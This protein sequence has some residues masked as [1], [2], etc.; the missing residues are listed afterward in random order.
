[1]LNFFM[2]GPDLVRWDLTALGPQGQPPFRLV[3]RH[4]KGTITEHFDTVTT[5][6]TRQ[7]ELEALLVAARAASRSEPVKVPPVENIPPHETRSSKPGPTILVLDDDRTVTETFAAALKREG[8]NVRTA[9]DAETGLLEANT[10]HADAIIVDLRMPLI[11]GLGF[12]YRLREWPEHRQTPVAIVTGA[13]VD[14]TT[15]AELAELGAE[16]RFKPLWLEDVVEL[17]RHLLARPA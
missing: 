3:V 10:H 9:V 5:A 13:V 4:A 8:F 7:G 17:A 14:D 12:L 16:L 15:M 6:L 1:V 2:A 11:N